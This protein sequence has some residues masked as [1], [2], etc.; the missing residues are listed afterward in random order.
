MGVKRTNQDIKFGR[1]IRLG[2]N[3]DLDNAVAGAVEV[4]AL[5]DTGTFMQR[6]N[7]TSWEIIA[8]PFVINVTNEDDFGTSVGGIVNLVDAVYVI[9]TT[10]VTSRTLNIPAGGNVEFKSIQTLQDFLIYTGTGT[11]ITGNPQRLLLDNLV[12]AGNASATFL[13]ITGTTAVRST[14]RLDGALITAFGTLGTST[15]V[16]TTAAFNVDMTNYTTGLIV[17]NTVG[18][19][20]FIWSGGRIGNEVTVTGANTGI[21]FT[22]ITSLINITD[23]TLRLNSSQNGFKFDNA[24][25]IQ[26]SIVV[27]SCPLNASL[28][29]L[30]LDSTGRGK[31]DIRLQVRN[32]GDSPD[33]ITAGTATMRANATSTSI[34]A[35]TPV[36]IAGTTTA[37]FLERV[38]HATNKLTYDG[39][40]T[41]TARVYAEIRLTFAADLQAETINLYVVKNGVSASPVANDESTLNGV[42]N[43]PTSPYLRAVD[44]VGNVVTDDFFEAWIESDGNDDIIV[45]SLNISFE[46]VG[47]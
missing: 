1:T 29:G 2:K 13:S 24:L 30:L 42:F 38:S 3:S 10:V 4:G 35:A 21:T 37:G 20:D 22:G 41:I 15:D 28:G 18:S 43:N 39:L 6:W 17:N 32:N 7:G 11:F 33:S 34:T 40:E 19:P 31:D 46:K 26:D 14:L 25:T 5:R 47:S 36:K 45:E 44:L 23:C 8:P 9:T 27:S 16:L 12:I